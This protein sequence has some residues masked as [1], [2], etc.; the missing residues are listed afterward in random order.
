MSNGTHLK[1]EQLGG[2]T[3]FSERVSKIW[4]TVEN[5]RHPNRP[6][7]LDY[8]QKLFTDYEEIRGDRSFAEDKALIAGIGTLRTADDTNGINLLFL[9]HQKGRTT[10]QKIER[11][12][13]MAKPEGY[14]K[15]IRALAMAERF[16]LPV[17]SFIDTPGA[18]PGIGA[19][20]RGQSEA[21]AKCIQKIFECRSASVGIVIG[22]GG[23]G[24]ALAIGVTDRLLM[25]EN[26]TY[27]VISPESCAAILWGSASE[28]KRA[29]VA[30]NLTA[31]KSFELGICDEV[32]E[33]KGAGAHE[34]ADNAFLVLG[35]R[36]CFHLKDLLKLSDDDRLDKRFKKYR[37]MGST[38][39][40]SRAK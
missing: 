35:E 38:T 5:S 4:T 23:S 19:E 25:L 14:R 16:K 36:I 12:F 9:G 40:R 7:T 32:I 17:V 37:N 28:S 6:H 27:S 22:E 24:G 29:A 33:E 26:S 31:K 34:S 2:E 15:V 13:G 18:Y 39:L 8:L 1:T 20:E 3:K 10:K 11:N 21:I 30:L